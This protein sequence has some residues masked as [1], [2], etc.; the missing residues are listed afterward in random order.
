MKQNLNDINGRIAAVRMGKWQN[1]LADRWRFY[2]LD[3]LMETH[4]ALCPICSNA[5]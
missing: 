5:P 2:F 4:D 3:E 1:T